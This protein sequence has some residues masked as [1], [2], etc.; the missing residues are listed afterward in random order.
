MPAKFRVS[1]TAPHSAAPPAWAVQRGPQKGTRPSGVASSATR[2]AVPFAPGAPKAGTL[3]N[4]GFGN[5]GETRQYQVP[6][7]LLELARN[8]KKDRALSAAVTPVVPKPVAES[9]PPSGELSSLPQAA[10]AAPEPADPIT[11][12]EYS[13]QSDAAE[14]SLA[15]IAQSGIVR[16][17]VPLALGRWL[18]VA[19]LYLVA[20]Y[21]L[22]IGLRVLFAM[23]G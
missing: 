14:A 21:Y 19:S 20:C 1:P 8:K 3:G 4:A 12:V 5:G 17:H 16:R 11:D 18:L 6:N 9:V 10:A 15:P 22:Q 13:S 7:E 23:P 2:V